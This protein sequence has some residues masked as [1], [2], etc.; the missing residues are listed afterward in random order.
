MIFFLFSSRPS[1]QPVFADTTKHSWGLQVYG[2]ATR[3]HH[4]IEYLP[5]AGVGLAIERRIA[6]NQ[7]AIAAGVEYARAA[8]VLTLI[9]G[10]KKIHTD[11]Y[12][13]FVAAR[14]EWQPRR[15]SRLAFVLELQTGVLLLRSRPWTFDAGTFGKIQFSPKSEAK[16]ALAWSGGAAFRVSERV[17]VLL[18][19]KQNFSRFAQRQIGVAEKPKA[20]RPRW[21]FAAGL[22]WQF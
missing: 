19:V 2:F 15:Q 1:I 17:A 8:Q 22:S 20:W 5:G 14:G 11:L 21:H 9:G 13:S 7:L 10:S 6:Q 18:F 16:L 12:Q 4:V 3:Y